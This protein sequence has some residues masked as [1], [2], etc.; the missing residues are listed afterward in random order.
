MVA[1]HS[2]LAV[3]HGLSIT[4]MTEQSMHNKVMHSF[5]LLVWFHILLKDTADGE[6]SRVK[7]R[8][9]MHLKRHPEDQIGYVGVKDSESFAQ[10]GSQQMSMPGSRSKLEKRE[11]INMKPEEVVE[12]KEE[13]G[14]VGTLSGIMSKYEYICEPSGK[15]GILWFMTH[16]SWP[17]T[18]YSWFMAIIPG[19]LEVAAV[20]L[21]C[22][23]GSEVGGV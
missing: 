11:F 1:A 10:F 19:V 17:M 16:G 9:A 21:Q 5:D 6:F 3:E 14:K 15:V 20:L 12:R 2:E 8:L 22:L 23:S 18:H 13:V 4:H 7:T